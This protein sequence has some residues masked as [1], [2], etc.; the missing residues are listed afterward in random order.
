VEAGA[1]DADLLA[2]LC[3]YGLVTCDAWTEGEALARRILR[4]ARDGILVAHP[5]LAHA[6]LIELLWRRGEW[7]AVWAE[8]T[9]LLNILESG[10]LRQ[11]APVG[12]AL[13]ARILA[14]RGDDA[15]CRAAAAAALAAAEPIGLHQVAAIAHSAV[16]LLHLG[17][18]DHADAAVAFDRV[19]VLAARL[20]EPGWLWWQADAVEAH[21]GCGDLVTAEET[22]RRL[23]QEAEATGRVWAGA[24]ANRARALLLGAQPDGPPGDDE[25]AAAIDQLFTS[26]IDRFRDLGAPF[27][28]ARSHLARGRHRRRTGRRPEGDADAAAARRLFQN[29]RARAWL[30][31]A[32]ED[33]SSEADPL[34]GLTP[35]E[36]E[37]VLAYADGDTYAEIAAQLGMTTNTVD[38]HLDNARRKL[39]I[40][41]SDLRQRARRDRT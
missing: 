13:E 15:G 4:Q 34:E 27:E 24:A 6:V 32:S 8:L 2:Q 9:D 25:R 30:E 23:E 5:T 14:A 3:A 41:R 37:V 22:L 10:G 33:A 26:A 7:A 11:Y 19:A 12:R 28:T 31:R 35:K 16:G 40:R 38:W 17:A 1:P 20:R 18:G 21:V 39:G 29:L 36:R